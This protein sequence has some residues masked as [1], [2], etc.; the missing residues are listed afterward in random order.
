MTNYHIHIDNQIEETNKEI[1]ID[2]WTIENDD[3]VFSMDKLKGKYSLTQNNIVKII[4]KYSYCLVYEI[5]SVCENKFDRKVET[6]G[7]FKSKNNAIRCVKCENEYLEEQAKDLKVKNEEHRKFLEQLE[8][9]KEQKF[10]LAIKNKR[11]LDLDDYQLEVLKKI[12]QSENLR[13]IKRTVFNG[14]FYNKFV[15][16][17]VN[18]LDKLGLIIIE[19]GWNNQVENIVYSE[20]LIRYLNTPFKSKIVDYLSFSLSK[21]DNKTT[22]RQPDYSGTFTLPTDV[23]LKSGVKYIYGGWI[24]TDNSINLKFTPISDIESVKQTKTEEEPKIISDIISDFF[25]VMK[26]NEE[27][28]VE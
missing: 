11:W 27:D 23:V 6:K 20:D 8:N 16:S 28:I 2:Y 26:M 12:L 18:K 14:D 19:R 24:Q 3:F 21:K 1:V 7:N 25:N 4:K 5:C 17:A 22:A 10:E 9:E 13:D 15:W